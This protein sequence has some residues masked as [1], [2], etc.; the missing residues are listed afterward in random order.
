MARLPGADADVVA[1]AEHAYVFSYPLLLS[2]RAMRRA[3]RLFLGPGPADTMRISGWL[4]L[5][6]Q[7]RALSLD[8]T[9]GRYYVVWLRDAWNNVYAS[10]GARSTGTAARAF[11]VLGPTRRGDRLPAPLSPIA[12][13]TRITRVSGCIEAVGATAPELAARVCLCDLSRWAGVGSGIPLTP[14]ERDDDDLPSRVAEVERMDAASH[15]AE[16]L[17]LAADNPPEADD[18]PALDELGAVLAGGERRSLEEGAR[19]GREAIRRA[20]EAGGEHAGPWRF[21]YDL[22]RYGRD[23]LRRAA[24][25]RR[26]RGV[27]PAPDE[28]TGVAEQDADGRPLTGR[29]RYLLRFP[30]RATPP[31]GAFWTLATPAGSTG[32]LRGLTLDADGSLPIH[33]QRDAPEYGGNWLPAPAGRFSLVLRLYWPSEQALDRRWTPPAPSRLAAA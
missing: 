13:P 12:A 10:V 25:A 2:Q 14:V 26:G 33:I 9:F 21:E 18:R 11:A 6:S 5:G 16:A 4:D 22:G 7:P 31:A 20:A 32:G 23:H 17:R 8:D 29:G 19:R 24:A 30:P 1:R 3:N 28:L 27:E 15:F